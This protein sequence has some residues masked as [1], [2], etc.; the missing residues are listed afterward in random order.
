M[1]TDTDP[2]TPDVVRNVARS[3]ASVLPLIILLVLTTAVAWVAYKA[4][5]ALQEILNAPA[6]TTPEQAPQPATKSVTP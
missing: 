5:P 3:K 6:V 4:W 1:T 2:R